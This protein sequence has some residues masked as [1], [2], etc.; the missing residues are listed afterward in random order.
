MKKKMLTSIMVMASIALAFGYA[1]PRTL[2]ATEVE[3]AECEHKIDKTVGSELLGYSN[4]MVEHYATGKSDCEGKTGSWK[5]AVCGHNAMMRW[6]GW[7]KHA[8]PFK[9]SVDKCYYRWEPDGSTYC[10]YEW[11]GGSHYWE[12]HFASVTNNSIPFGHFIVG[13]YRGGGMSDFDN[14]NFYQYND[15]GIQPDSS[16]MPCGTNTENTRIRVAKTVHSASCTGMSATEWI[17]WEI[18]EDCQVHDVETMK[19][20]TMSDTELKKAQMDWINPKIEGL[21]KV[22]EMQISGW[23]ADLEGSEIDFMVYKL[24]PENQRLDDTWIGEWKINVWEDQG[25]R[26]TR[27][28]IKDNKIFNHRTLR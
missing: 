13:W 22:P 9:D 14:W 1:Q 5:S 20:S 27:T 24:T 8:P 15:W 28:R 11:G 17:V 25:T 4:G 16:H 23:L 6:S 7:S 26:T 21:E 10:Y 12:D 19:S 3:C 18:D 2:E